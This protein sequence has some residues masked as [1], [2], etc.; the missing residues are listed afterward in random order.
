MSNAW[1][2]RRIPLVT[3]GTAVTSAKWRGGLGCLLVTGLSGT[4]D[5]EMSFDGTTWVDVKELGTGTEIAAISAAAMFN[6]LL[7]ACDIRMSA[8][9]GTMGVIAVGI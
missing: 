1:E 4:P 3:A 8:G 6:F 5:F 2:D 7:P 9:G